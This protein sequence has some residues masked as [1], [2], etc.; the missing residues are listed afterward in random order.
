MR[1]RD[2]DR[3][4]NGKIEE[5]GVTLPL[6]KEYLELPEAGRQGRILP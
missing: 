6:T 2:A 4:D 3:R 5:S 1:H